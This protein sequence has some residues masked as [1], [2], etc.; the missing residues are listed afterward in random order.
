MRE[1]DQMAGSF[2]WQQSAAGNSVKK[3]LHKVKGQDPRSSLT[4]AFEISRILVEFFPELRIASGNTVS[5]FIVAARA[6]SA[7]VVFLNI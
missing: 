6:S 4:H 3:G 1:T 5:I 2:R 7:S